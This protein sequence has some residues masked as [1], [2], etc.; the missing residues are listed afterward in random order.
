[1]QQQ[2]ANL[3]LPWHTQ[4]QQHNLQQ[5][6]QRLDTEVLEEQHVPGVGRFTATKGGRVRVRFEDR[7]IL[8]LA[9][10]GDSAELVMSDGSRQS[11]ATGNPMGVEE[12]VQVRTVH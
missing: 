10:G 4:Q 9:A 5:Q 11:V 6:Q 3:Q 12:Y 7:T 1:V 2:Q 8:N